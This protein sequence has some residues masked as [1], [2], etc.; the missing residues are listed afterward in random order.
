MNWFYALDRQQM[1]PVS[2]A[3][4]EELLQSGKISQDTLVWREG[5]V[6]WQP[7]RIARP[8]PPP[9]I[10]GQP[11]VMCVECGRHF[12]Q[13]DVI[14]LNNSWVCGGCK[15][16]FLQ[17]LREGAMPSGASGGFWRTKNLL[18]T[19]PQISLPDRCVRCNAPAY[20]FR[21]KRKFYWHP[22]AYFLFIFL[23]LLIYAI[24]AMCVRKGATLDIGLCEKHRA[25]RKQ[26]LIVCWTGVLIAVGMF[27]AA[28]VFES[29]VLTIGGIVLLLAGIIYAS[30]TGIRVSPSKITKENVW[31]KGVD[32][33]YLAE[34]PEWP[35][36]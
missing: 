13:D 32:A 11:A 27:I 17:R 4:L 25:R 31:L 8:G 22:P 16:T 21:L 23:N 9:I 2:N 5:M 15:P 1:G 7:L 30:I 12:S 34:L 24:V 35:G 28:G 20:G 19:H 36:A 33:N 3:Q 26:G 29:A 6:K 14:R 10:N 18:V